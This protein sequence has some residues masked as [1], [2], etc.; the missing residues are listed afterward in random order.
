MA[1]W[2]AISLQDLGNQAMSTTIE[3]TDAALNGI[4]FDPELFPALA[5]LRNDAFRAHCTLGLPTTKDEEWKYTSVRE[6]AERYFVHGGPKP[7]SEADLGSVGLPAVDQLRLV[8]VNG[9]F[10]PEL[11]SELG[12]VDGLNFAPLCKGLAENVD[13]RFG[14]LTKINDFTFAALN[15]ATFRCGAQIEFTKNAVIEPVVH[16][17]HIGVPDHNDTA[18]YHAARNFIVAE[19]GS[20]ATVLESYVTIGD[21]PIFCNA[22]TEVFVASN[23]HL[24]HVKVQTAGQNSYHISNSEVMQEADSSYNN[25]NV[26][27]GS[28]I[29]RNDLNVFLNGSNLH[30]RMDG[31]VVLSGDQHADNH[32]RLDHAYAHCD[33]FEVYKHILDGQTTAV[34]NGKIFVHEDAQKTDA[35]QTNQTLLLSPQA[36]I[37]SKPQLEIFADDVKCTHG[38]TVGYLDELPLFYLRSR[39]LPLKQAEAMMVYAF[40]AEVLEKITVPTLVEELEKMLFEKLGG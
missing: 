31:V 5:Q 21:G 28:K 29:S 10:N 9:I 16:I 24:Q 11:S 40:A 15:T 4:Q 8:F 32:T 25:Y 23:A 2:K 19:P 34:F 38:A 17:L 36:T 13:P 12:G 37:N 39:G 33:S 3:S 35:K 22:V 6:I 26:V 20:Q 14:S 30:S 7:V 1:G 27:L 18:S